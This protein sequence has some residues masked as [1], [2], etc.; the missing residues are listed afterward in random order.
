MNPIDRRDFLKTGASAL[1]LSLMGGAALSAPDAAATG[2]TLKKGYMLNTY[3]GK[4]LSVLE[5][6]RNIRA[7]GFDGVEANS[8][9][10]QEEVLRARDAAGLLIPSVVCGQHSRALANADPAKRGLAVEGVKQAVRDAKRCASSAMSAR[11]SRSGGRL[12]VMP[13]RRK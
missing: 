13:L 9:M 6:F 1:A 7:A 2:R 10:D 4:D 12:T 11:R 8:H 3:P 5:K